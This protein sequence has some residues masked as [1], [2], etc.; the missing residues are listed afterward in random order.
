[1]PL[2]KKKHATIEVYTVR[3]LSNSL[4]SFDHAL[5]VPHPNQRR[6]DIRSRMSPCRLLEFFGWVLKFQYS[7]GKYKQNAMVQRIKLRTAMA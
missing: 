7:A 3:G 1:M 6:K 5:K 2:M 4:P